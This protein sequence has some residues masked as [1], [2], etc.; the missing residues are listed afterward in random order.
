MKEQLW[1]GAP[2]TWTAGSQV[3]QNEQSLKHTEGQQEKMRVGW[4]CGRALH[5]TII[6][7]QGSEVMQGHTQGLY[8]NTSLRKKIYIKIFLCVFWCGMPW[9]SWCMHGWRLEDNLWGSVL[10]FHH[11]GPGNQAQVIRLGGKHVHHAAISLIR[12]IMVGKDLVRG[13]GLCWEMAATWN[14]AVIENTPQAKGE[15]KCLLDGEHG[16]QPTER[17]WQCA[18]VAE[19]NMWNESRSVCLIYF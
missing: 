14:T 18:S 16:R 11:V 9:L 8:W 10:S 3:P 19:R 15:N 5:R 4:W 13:G 2:E 7:L 6:Y 17:L 1:D 12:I